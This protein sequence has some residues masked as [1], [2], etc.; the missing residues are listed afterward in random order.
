MMKPFAYN[1]PQSSNE[2][3]R[4]QYFEGPKSVCHFYW[5][6]PSLSDDVLHIMNFGAPIVHFIRLETWFYANG[7]FEY[8]LFCVL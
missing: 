2:L 5:Y 6:G 1:C 7:S 3:K 8:D 4:V